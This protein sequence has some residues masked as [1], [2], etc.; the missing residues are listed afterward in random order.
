MAAGAPVVAVGAN[1]GADIE[2]VQ[3]HK[4]RAIWCRW[5]CLLAE[6]RER[7]VAV[8]D[9]EIAEHLVVGRFSLTM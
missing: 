7:G 2:V 6:Q 4:S 8:A 1:V 9:T 5:A 3:Q